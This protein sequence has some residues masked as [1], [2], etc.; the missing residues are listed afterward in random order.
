LP[1][2]TAELESTVVLLARIRE[3]DGEAEE[4]LV[5]RYLPLLKAWASGRLPA[6]ARA[7]A[8]TDD[9]V[10]VTLLRALKRT[11]DFDAQREG[12]FLAYLRQI[13]LNL[14]R[15]EIRR[16]NR[17]PTAGPVPEELHDGKPSI[18]EQQMGKE[19]MEAYETALA[20]LPERL[21]EAVIMRIEFGFDYRR[22]AESLGSPSPNAARMVVSRALARLSKRMEVHR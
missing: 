21:K 12:A 17:H 20:E 4:H 9:L 1:R 3:G 10:Q 19:M 14:L 16:S 8:D 5:A 6:G 7:L 2:P 13:L 11:G 15:D 22:I 18:V